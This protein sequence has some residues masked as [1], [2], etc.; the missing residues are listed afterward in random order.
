[1][2]SEK[3]PATPDPRIGK[4][5]SP[6]AEVLV[7]EGDGSNWV[8][9]QGFW[10]GARDQVFTVDPGETTDFAS[11]PRPLVWLI[12]RYGTYTLPAI[13]HDHLYRIEV[14]KKPPTI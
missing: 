10:Y 12:A 1:M 7:R 3:A 14:K 8:L 6:D 4:G 13:L 5:F 9:E 11:V 2:T